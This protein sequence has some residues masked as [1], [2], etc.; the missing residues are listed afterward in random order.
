MSRKFNEALDTIY[1][2][3]DVHYSKYHDDPKLEIVFS[4]KFY[5]DM[6]DEPFS[7]S[8]FMNELWMYHTIWGYPVR[9]DNEQRN[10]TF[11]VVNHSKPFVQFVNDLS[12][13]GMAAYC[14]NPET[15]E[16]NFGD[17]TEQIQLWIDETCIKEPKSDKLDIK[18]EDM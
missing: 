15:L 4:P 11:T 6:M 10:D 8:S 16:Q 13:F 5:H 9:I 12:T 18:L 14:I 2:V 1:Y 3:R 17:C 7:S